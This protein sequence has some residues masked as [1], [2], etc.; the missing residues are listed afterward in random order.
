MSV[1]EL[2]AYFEGIT[3]PQKVELVT[4][5]V[6]EDVP[7]FLESHFDYIRDNPG[8]KSID[9]FLKRLNDLHVILESKAD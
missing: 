1:D 3:L 7:L 8:L 5:V 6:I 2:E 9:I 4:G